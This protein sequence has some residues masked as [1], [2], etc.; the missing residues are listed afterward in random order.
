M[1]VKT[2][3]NPE[4]IGFLIELARGVRVNRVRVRFFFFLNDF[5]E[6]QTM[7]FRQTIHK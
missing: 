7:E 2:E 6:L 4:K 1:A 5:I 3:S